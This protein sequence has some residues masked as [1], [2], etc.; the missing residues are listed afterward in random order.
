V[1]VLRGLQR[2]L[3]DLGW[4]RATRSSPDALAGLLEAGRPRPSGEFHLFEA[5]LQLL[6]DVCSERLLVVLLEDLQWADQATLSLVDFLHRHA[7]HLP[8]LVLG[9][10]R[11]DEVAQ[12]D[13][14]HQRA[15]AD[16]AQKA[17]TVPLTGLDNDGIRKLRETLG[18]ATSTAEAEHLRRLTGGN[19]FFVI[20]SA[21]FTDPA[22]SLGVRR[23]IDRRLDALGDSERFVLTVASLV[24]REVPDALLEAIVDHGTGTPLRVIERAGLMRAQQGQHAFVHDLVRESMRDRLP[25]DERRALYARI[26][27]AADSPVL[28][29]HLLPAQLAWLAT[30]AVPDIPAQQAIVL[31][32]T[33]ADDA[34]ARQTHEAAGRHYEEAAALAGDPEER[35]RLALLSGD[36]YHRAG[37]LALARERYASLLGAAPVEVRAHALVGLHRLGDPAAVGEPSDAVR[38]LDAIDAELS[39]T[40]DTRLRAEVLA[41][42]SRSRTHLLADD[43]SAAA[44]MAAEALELARAAGDEA[45][46]ASCLLAYHDAIWEPGTEDERRVLADQLAAAGR[47]V[48]DPAVEAQGLLLRMVAELE[49]GDPR[50]LTTHASF[51]AVAKASRSPRLQ[52]VATSRRGTLAALRGDLPAALVEVDAA[53]ALGERI[54]EPDAIGMW[55]DQRWVVAHHAGDEGTI[56]ELIAALR[57]MGDPHW[58]VYEA[59]VAAEHGDVESATRIAPD[60]AALCE[61]WPRW[62]ARLWDVLNAQLA[63]VSHDIAGIARLV[64]RLEADAGHWAVLGGGVL[65]HGPMS[66]WLGRLEAGRG[67]WQ[68]AGSWAS[69]AEA[70]AQRLDARLWALEAHAD[71]LIAARA[72]NAVDRTDLAATISSARE[73]GLVPIAERLEAL[74]PGAPTGT[75]NVFRREGDVWTLVFDGVVAQMPDA[76]GL[77]D[78]RTLL[79][80]PHVD[81]AATS[82]ATDAFVSADA[83]AIL[84]ARAKEA[85]RRRLDDI[86]REL[87]RTAVRGDARRAAVLEKEREA[88]LDELRRAAGLGGRSRA[89]N[90]DRERLRKTVTARV[91]DTLRRLDDRHPALA[92]HLR[93]SVHTGA[94]CVYAPREPVSWDLGT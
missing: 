85:Y 91:R 45:T 65:V 68:R 88:L 54:G 26:V 12:P 4:D 90:S 82:L 32:E 84:D 6:T 48:G 29:A 28:A 47:R 62:A 38:Q 9:T 94:N 86:D 71:R 52:F 58:M 34:S 35:A 64:E 19:P 16:L 41:A 30:Q 77:H 23:A 53:R 40:A 80:N 72:V 31:L 15:I 50:Y 13:H 39:G 83:P 46:V 78:L 69:E 36:A 21:A 14:P 74:E 2:L 17:I 73:R 22:E 66:L 56:A 1:Q 11:A 33:A 63:I 57:D 8:L 59:M 61:R 92:A 37:A 81:I 55:C 24:G 44:P 10:Y 25:A 5:T 79:A 18:V 42:R 70:A 75:V 87:D 20:E 93:A 60:V 49:T 7:V 27:R 76:K 67:D 51:D 3:G 89:M 43:R